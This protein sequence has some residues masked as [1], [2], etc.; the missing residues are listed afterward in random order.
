[1]LFRL[2]VDEVNPFVHQKFTEL[3]AG[4]EH[5]LVKHVLPHGNPHFHAYADLDY[6][7][8]QALRY[9]IDKLF[10]VTKSDQRSVTKCDSDR[11]EE[12]IQYL[13]N[14]KKGNKWTLVSSTIDVTDHQAKAKLVTDEFVKTRKAKKDT[15]PT[16]WDLAQYVQ[17][18]VGADPAI[19]DNEHELYSQYVRHAIAIHREYKKPF[20]SFSIV[21]VIQTA[22][23][24]SSR[25]ASQRFLHRAIMDRLIPRN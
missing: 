15:G 16:V 14:D 4:H 24:G 22:M 21:K 1:M 19:P 23:S 2:R 11:K 17:T 13:F 12:Y 3:L 25:E 5:V 7:S 10:D 8:P 9:Q 20:C 6:K 18:A